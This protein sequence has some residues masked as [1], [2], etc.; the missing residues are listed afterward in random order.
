PKSVKSTAKEIVKQTEHMTLLV[1]DMLMLSRLENLKEKS[2]QKENLTNVLSEVK[3]ALLPIAN[4][5]SIKIDIKS[6]FI[7]MM[8]DLIDIQKLFKNVI[9]N[10]IKYSDPEKI[11]TVTLKKQDD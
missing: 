10:A 5:K 2:Y 8:C 4:Q 6:E 7:E 3:N 11:V 9:E 1:E